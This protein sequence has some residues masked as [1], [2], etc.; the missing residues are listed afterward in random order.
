MR[1]QDR[2][3]LLDNASVHFFNRWRRIED[4]DGL[5]SFSRFNQEALP[6]ALVKVALPAFQPIRRPTPARLRVLQRHVE[7]DGQVGFEP[8]RGN[9]TSSPQLSDVQAAAM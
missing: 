7:N 5:R 9:S 8:A 2:L 6:D 4:P 3:H 1:C